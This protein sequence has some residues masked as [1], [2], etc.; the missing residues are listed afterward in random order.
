VTLNLPTGR[1][2]QRTAVLLLLLGLVAGW[3]LVAEPLVELYA[4]RHAELEQKALLA[5]HLEAMAA[6]LPRLKALPAMQGPPPAVTLIGATD[7]MAA[8]TLQGSVQDMAAVVGGSLGSVEILP[9]EPVGGLR[10][11]G[12]KV[13]LTGSPETIVALL[14]AIE[15]STPPMLIDELQI[16]GNVLPIA[17]NAPGAQALPPMLNTSFAVYGY[18]LDQPEGRRP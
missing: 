8:A 16:H 14:A 9:A 5:A 7:A 11:I 2:G 18:R 3:R 1:A 4:A 13:S 6:E 17:V 10:R 15:E 12:L